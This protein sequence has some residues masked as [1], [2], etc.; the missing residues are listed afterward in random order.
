[1]GLFQLSFLSFSLYSTVDLAYLCTYFSTEVKKKCINPSEPQVFHSK[2]S[3]L[4]INIGIFYALVA[5]S[6]LVERKNAL[7][8]AVLTTNENYLFR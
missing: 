5:I 4:E 1:M 8:R 7:V 6:Y 2:K 3:M